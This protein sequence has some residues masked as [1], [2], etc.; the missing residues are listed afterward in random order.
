MLRAAIDIPESALSASPWVE[1]AE[2]K[3]NLADRWLLGMAGRLSVAASCVSVWRLRRFS[4]QVFELESEFSALSEQALQQRVLQ[5]SSELRQAGLR[6]DVVAK[7]FALVREAT[8]RAVGKRHFDVQVIGGRV[9]LDGR[10]AEMQT[11]EGKTLTALLPAAT[12]AL[13]GVPVHVVTVNEYLAA[14]DADQL[15]PV[16]R[17]LGLSVGK[18]LPD[19]S[20]AD[21]ARAYSCRVT[22]CVNKELTFDYLRD[23]I[24]TLAGRH[25]ARAQLARLG[26][27]HTPV[28]P[29]LTNGLWYALID[30][31]DSVFVDEARTPLI[32]SRSGSSSRAATES[33]AA[34]ALAKTLQQ[35]VHFNVEARDR[36]IDLLESG[37]QLLQQCQVPALPIPKIQ[38]ERLLAQ[39][40]TALHCYELDRHYIVVDGKI[41]I[42][43]EF[44]G[45]VMPDRAWEGGL[46][47]MIERKE[48]LQATAPRETS[49]R[50]TYQRLFRR[51]LRLGGM[52]GT[53]SEASGELKAVLGVRVVRIP[54][55]RPVLRKGFATR[56]F[57]SAQQRDAAVVASAA[58]MVAAGRAVLIG[59]RSVAASE[60]IAALC[61]A[62]GLGLTL[63]NAR[64]DADEA[65]IVSQAGQ[66]GQLT[67]ATNMA[68]RGTDITLAP[69][70]L[71]AGGLHVILTEFHESRR[72][73]R[74]LAGRAGRQ[75]D[76]GSWQALVSLDD[77]IFTTQAHRVSR[78]LGARFPT[79]VPRWIA[80]VLRWLTQA[81]AE[82]Q[83]AETRRNTLSQ[84]QRTDQTLAFAGRPE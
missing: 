4:V 78:W 57:V 42:V 46:H 79:E 56:L 40:L 9:M 37:R 63:L 25:G 36:R 44:T 81:A 77:E 83:H 47:Q 18:V 84:E 29:P 70:V 30:E 16:Y 14:R 1:R 8:F 6:Q 69:S 21:R 12:M 61:R 38:R 49:A 3:Q 45:R 13:A 80:V 68:G 64:Q 51:Y 72:I 26:T 74:Q 11:G 65:G 5:A 34:L 50:I 32:I 60:R 35:Q 76:R 24:E 7:T 58:A 55:Y 23:R 75:G 54:T 71:S 10:F 66:S 48:G 41:Q 39:A 52:S 33:D 53:L 2:V 22:Y 28:A 17:L 31:A 19:Q 82:R 20:P 59:T 73:D 62:A 67:V 15:E 27:P 43:D